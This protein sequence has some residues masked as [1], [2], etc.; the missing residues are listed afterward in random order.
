MVRVMKDSNL[1][2][3]TRQTALELLL[4]LVESAPG[5]IRKQPDFCNQI[6]PVALEMMTDLEDED[7]WYST[8]DVSIL[9]SFA[10]RIC[11][12]THQIDGAKVPI[13]VN[14]SFKLLH[15]FS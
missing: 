14:C 10:Q 9:F 3:R 2:D 8:D 13:A 11:Q 4:T 6:I 5:M 1:E 12:Y 7:K 15:T